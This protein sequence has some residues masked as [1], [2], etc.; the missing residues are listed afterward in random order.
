MVE[1]PGE[2]GSQPVVPSPTLIADFIRNDLFG[3]DVGRSQYGRRYGWE[4]RERHQVQLIKTNLGGS[5]GTI[6]NGTGQPKRM[7]GIHTVDQGRSS[8][9]SPG[10]LTTAIVRFVQ[11]LEKRHA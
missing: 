11:T 5:W 8:R 1:K 2:P 6:G 10:R 3:L 9:T 4:S 7:A